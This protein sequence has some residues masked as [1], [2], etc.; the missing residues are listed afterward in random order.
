MGKQEEIEEAA[1]IATLT[2]NVANLTKAV[3]RLTEHVAR[4]E[5]RMWLLLLA[6]FGGGAGVTKIA[7]IMG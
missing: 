7:E 3:D 4:L 5:T 1:T 6:A 2:A